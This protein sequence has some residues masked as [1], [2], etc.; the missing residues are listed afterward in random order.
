MTLKTAV[1]A[2]SPLAEWSF[3]NTSK[4]TGAA[5]LMVAVS[6]TAVTLRRTRGSNETIAYDLFQLPG[7]RRDVE[8]RELKE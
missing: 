2:S 6:L 4:V 3:A 8:R 7:F 1:S 5:P